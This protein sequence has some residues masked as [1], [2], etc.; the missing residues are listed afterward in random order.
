MLEWVAGGLLV[1][2]IIVFGVI[3]FHAFVT[4]LIHA[5]YAN[6]FEEDEDQ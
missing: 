5:S 3:S 1:V 2:G 4:F 6:P